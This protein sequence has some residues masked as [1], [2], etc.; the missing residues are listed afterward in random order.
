MQNIKD[1][2]AKKMSIIKVIDD[3]YYHRGIKGFYAGFNINLI[4][5]LPNTAIMFVSY[6]YISRMIAHMNN[7][8]KRI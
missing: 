2:K 1:Y 6:E 4:K 5:I 8:T 7:Y 3:V